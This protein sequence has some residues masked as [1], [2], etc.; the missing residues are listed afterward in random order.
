VEGGWVGDSANPPE[1][2]REEREK[3]EKREK[4]RRRRGKGV[5]EESSYVQR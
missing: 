3:R 1:R 2:E 5:R 4:E